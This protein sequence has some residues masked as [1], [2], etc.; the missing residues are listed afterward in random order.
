M[1]KSAVHAIGRN[2]IDVGSDS[3][4]KAEGH[5]EEGA[6]GGGGGGQARSMK[7]DAIAWQTRGNRGKQGTGWGGKGE[8]GEG[9]RRDTYLDHVIALPDKEEVVVMNALLPPLDAS[10]Q[11][12]QDSK[13]DPALGCVGIQADVFYKRHHESPVEAIAVPCIP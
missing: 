6:G 8:K 9:Q 5:Q 2:L 4:S 10:V 7:G 11:P 3:G 1:G 12:L 13:Q